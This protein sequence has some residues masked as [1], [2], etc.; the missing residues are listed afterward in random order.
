MRI[1]DEQIS[2]IYLELGINSNDDFLDL[3]LIN[4]GEYF[5]EDYSESYARSTIALEVRLGYESI[6][7]I[8]GD[9]YNIRRMNRASFN[10]SEIIVDADINS[11]F[12]GVCMHDLVYLIHKNTK[13]LDCVSFLDFV[14]CKN[15]SIRRL[16]LDNINVILENSLNVDMDYVFI[17]TIKPENI[18]FEIEGL[19]NY[20]NVECNR[21]SNTDESEFLKGLGF[22]IVNE[23][24]YA[25]IKK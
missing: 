17:S 8:K 10:K 11:S 20:D 22:K 19:W 9:L 3:K 5:V 4:R 7:Y 13:N 15:E 24:L 23:D 14:F 12:D 1:K 25:W 18:E 16:L 2:E 21:E 6:G